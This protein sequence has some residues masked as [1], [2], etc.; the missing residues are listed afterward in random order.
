[1]T[2]ATNED[3]VRAFHL[4]GLQ[5]TEFDLRCVV[6]ELPMITV[7]RRVSREELEAV[8]FDLHNPAAVTCSDVNDEPLTWQE[9]LECT[10]SRNRGIVA[11][12]F[13]GIRN[14]VHDARM[15][16]NIAVKR[17]F[18]ELDTSIWKL[19]Y[20]PWT[21]PHIAALL[22]PDASPDGGLP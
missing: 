20:L 7:T 22:W 2:L 16:R 5:V 3:I 10:A 19:R 15:Q 4:E 18:K 11:E 17:T 14:G 12:W 6:G 21:E 1:M 13:A 9:T 8:R